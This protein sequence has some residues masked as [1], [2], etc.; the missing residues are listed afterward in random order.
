MPAA[1]VSLPLAVAAATAGAGL[2]ATGSGAG[3]GATALGIDTT[4]APGPTG[5]DGGAGMAAGGPNPR[6]TRETNKSS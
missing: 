2:T 3:S 4:V 5:I 1:P 6:S